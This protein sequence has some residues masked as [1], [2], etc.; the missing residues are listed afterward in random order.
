[1][2]EEYP[3]TLVS[4]LV[5]VSVV[6]VLDAPIPKPVPTLVPKSFSRAYFKILNPLHEPP[7]PNQFCKEALMPMEYF[8]KI[9]NMGHYA[10]SGIP[11]LLETKQFF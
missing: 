2:D 4:A 8:S 3:R 6:F 1:M 10:L 5:W 9:L 7:M 11:V